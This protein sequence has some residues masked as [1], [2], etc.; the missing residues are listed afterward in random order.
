MAKVLFVIRHVLATPR[1]FVN[2]TCYWGV[3]KLCLKWSPEKKQICFRFNTPCKKHIHD[4]FSSRY[5]STYFYPSETSVMPSHTKKKPLQTVE[6]CLPNQNRYVGTQNKQKEF[7][8]QGSFYWKNGD[9]YEGAFIRGMMQGIGRKSWNDGRL[10]E[11]QW[12]QDLP[13]GTGFSVWPDGEEYRGQW[14]A[15]LFDG[16]GK[17]IKPNGDVYVGDFSNGKE[18]GEGTFVSSKG[19]TYLGTYH[20]GRMAGEGEIRYGDGRRYSGQWQDSKFHG[21]GM[22]SWPDGSSYEGAFNTGFRDGEGVHRLPSGAVYSG[23]HRKDHYHGKGRMIWPDGKQYSGGWRI[24]RPHGPGTLRWPSGSALHCMWHQ[25]KP[26]D[27]GRKEYPHGAVY[28]GSMSSCRPHGEG[29]MVWAD[30][31]QYTGLFDNGQACGDGT[32]VFPLPNADGELVPAR[33]STTFAAGLAHGSGV[34][35]LPDGSA[36]E[37]GFVRGRMEG[38]GTYRWGPSGLLYTGGLRAGKLEGRGVLVYPNGSFY[39]GDFLA[40]EFSGEG[41]YIRPLR[42]VPSGMLVQGSADM[43]TAEASAAITAAVARSRGSSRSSVRVRSKEEADDDT[44]S[45]FNDSRHLIRMKRADDDSSVTVRAVRYLAK[46][47][48]SWLH[49]QPDGEGTYYWGEN[50]CRYRGQFTRGRF[51]G[52]GR[53]AWGDREYVGGFRNGVEHG[54]GV[55]REGSIRLAGEWCDGTLHRRVIEIPDLEQGRTILAGISDGPGVVEQASAIVLRHFPDGDPPPSEV[56]SSVSPCHGILIYQGGT[57]YIGEISR[58]EGSWGKK[59]GEGVLIMPDGETRR[60]LWVNDTLDGVV[61]P[62]AEKMTTSSS[63]IDS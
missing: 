11:G 17:R 9:V 21:F 40:G 6:I 38:L 46:Y 28:S 4:Y 3:K 41:T 53:L 35:M 5:I 29:V 56:G 36:Y 44:R 33:L 15:G 43:H 24:G 19:W 23:Q 1:R 60:G 25:G 34:L 45:K 39:E 14:R 61:Y 2:A 48:G 42:P 51:H 10:Y 20:A 30:G 37:G 27:Q 55:L 49:S 57:R 50:G 12:K 52:S 32:L 7:H 59:H 13:H 54:R 63:V 18:E 8:G 62:V 58:A 22:A 16:H 31:R 26:A 47:A